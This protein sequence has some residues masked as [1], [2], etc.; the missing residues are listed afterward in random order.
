M[1]PYVRIT[2]WCKGHG[3]QFSFKLWHLNDAQ[4]PT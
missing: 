2:L 3:K 1:V 4:G